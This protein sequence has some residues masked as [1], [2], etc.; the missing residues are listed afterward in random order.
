[1]EIGMIGSDVYIGESGNPANLIV[2]TGGNLGTLD[3]AICVGDDDSSLCPG[4]STDGT[5]YYDTGTS[6]YDLA[7]EFKTKTKL[8]PGDLVIASDEKE[9]VELTTSSYDP[10]LIGVVATRPNI[11]FRLDGW[12]SLGDKADRTSGTSAPISLVGRVPVK[13]ST[14]NGPIEVGDYL[15]SSNKPGVAKKATKPGTIIGKALEDFDGEQGKILVFINLGW[16]GGKLTEDGT[17]ASEQ[18]NID[19]EH[20][21]LPPSSDSNIVSEIISVLEQIG[22]TIKDGI[23]NITKLAVEQ[24]R[25]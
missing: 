16:Y 5:L 19:I 3:G 12:S 24:F 14:E 13:V 2:D 8:E 25:Q 10:K 6:A 21:I 18:D 15:T 20:P 22:I 4:G 9:T 7:E 1:M 17:I 11:L 23:T